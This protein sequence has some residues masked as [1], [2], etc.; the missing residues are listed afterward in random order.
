MPIFRRRFPAAGGSA[1]VASSS[2]RSPL[3][4]FPPLLLWQV[5]AVLG[6]LRFWRAARQI[7]PA[8]LPLCLVVPLRCWGFGCCCSYRLSFAAVLISWQVVRLGCR[9]RSLRQV[10][11]AASLVG[12]AACALFGWWLL[13]SSALPRLL[14]AGSSAVAFVGR[15]RRR[16]WWAALVAAGYA[17][18]LIS[19]QISPPLVVALILW[20]GVRQVCRGRG[21]AGGCCRP[22]LRSVPPLILPAVLGCIMPRGGFAPAARG[23]FR[24][25]LLFCAAGADLVGLR[26]GCFAAAACMIDLL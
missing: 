13:I 10:L 23:R 21:R 14:V 15:F 3:A 9:A 6:C 24:P 12:L 4:D 1:S 16:G 11:R 26:R 7:S 20:Q 17:A 25:P 5:S 19:W 22:A 8:A 2:G 18:P